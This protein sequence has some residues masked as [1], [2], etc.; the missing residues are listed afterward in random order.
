[1]TSPTSAPPPPATLRAF[2]SGRVQGVG[3]RFY[4]YGQARKLGL[5]GMVRNLP[6]GRVEVHAG[7]PREALEQFVGVLEKG[8]ALSRVDRVE[9]DWKAEPPEP[10]PFSI[11]G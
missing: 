2:V 5:E 4:A 11:G 1:M 7:G 10:G 9:L 8:P 6:D 3:F